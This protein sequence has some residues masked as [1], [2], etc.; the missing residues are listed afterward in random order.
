MLSASQRGYG[1]QERVGVARGS[2]FGGGL[3]GIISM[4]F[5]QLIS[6]HGAQKI[7]NQD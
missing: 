5:G 2:W 4:D 3:K 6:K 1:H 7:S